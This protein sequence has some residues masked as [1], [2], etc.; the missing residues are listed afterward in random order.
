[1]LDVTPDDE[2][3][4]DVA[5]AIHLGIDRNRRPRPDIKKK[6]LFFIVTQLVF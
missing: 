1:M 2:K 6:V 4:H 5:E 3:I